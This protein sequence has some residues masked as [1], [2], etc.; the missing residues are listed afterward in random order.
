VGRAASSGNAA[1]IAIF[2]SSFNCSTVIDSFFCVFRVK[3]DKDEESDEE[4]A[5]FASET[6]E[7]SV[8]L[9]VLSSKANCIHCFT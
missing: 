8:S 1:P 2:S 3:G 5:L 7:R 9:A 6:D 4:R